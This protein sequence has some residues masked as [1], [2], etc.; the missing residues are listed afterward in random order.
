MNLMRLNATEMPV[1]ATDIDLFWHSHQ[2]TPSN[3]LPWG[4]HHIDL[5]VNLECT[6]SVGLRSTSK[7][8]VS[9]M[10]R[11]CEA[12]HLYEKC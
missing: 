3:F 5:P 4:N 12:M 9:F 1:P 8:L 11:T 2:L 7:S 6:I 10:T